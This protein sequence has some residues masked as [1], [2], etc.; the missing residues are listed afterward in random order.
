MTDRTDWIFIFIFFSQLDDWVLCRIYNKKGAIEKRDVSGQSMMSAVTSEDERKPVIMTSVPESEAVVYDDLVY[1]NPSD[2]V[3]RLHT[4]SSCS[5]HVVSPEFAPEVESAPK[6][7]DWDKTALDFP[8]NYLDASGPNPVGGALIGSQFQS[9][10]PME[11]LT[12]M[13]AYLSKPF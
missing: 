5:E 9:N 8:F 3:P 4:D 12:D 11:P 10:Y 1:F 13:Y 7:M 2:S 6:L